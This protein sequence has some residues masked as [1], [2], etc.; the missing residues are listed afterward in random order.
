MLTPI[1]I[2]KQEF[3]VKFRG[4]NADEVDN[5]LDLVGSDYEK[6]YKEN[7]ELKQQLKTLSKEIENYRAMENSLK[8]SIVL[9]QSA[10]DDV[11]KNASEKAA[12]IIEVAN[13]EAKDILK[14][15]ELQLAEKKQELENVRMQI[16]KY[17]ANIKG[18]CSGILEFLE[19][20]E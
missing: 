16:G 5:F 7:I 17:Q 6:L 10:A 18:I 13:S 11:K 19:K 14:G 2:Q 9:A 8:E 4:Y 12:N 15:V 20:I 1:D 3:D